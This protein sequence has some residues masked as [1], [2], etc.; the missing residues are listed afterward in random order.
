MWAMATLGA[1]GFVAA[2]IGLVTG[3]ADLTQSGMIA[4]LVASVVFLRYRVNNLE[5]RRE[6]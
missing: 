1:L 5:N 6:P 3:D 4:Y 2:T